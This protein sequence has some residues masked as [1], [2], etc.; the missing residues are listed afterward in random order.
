VIYDPKDRWNPPEGV[1]ARGRVSE[2]KVAISLN[3]KLGYAD[4]DGNV[5]VQPQF[6][7]AE[8]FYE[9]RA[10]VCKQGR[11]GYINPA[12]KLVIL[13]QYRGCSWFDSGVAIVKPYDQS[14]PLLIDKDGNLVREF[15][16]PWKVP[17]G[18]FSGFVGGLI[19][20]N[21]DDD[22][23]EDP[24][25]FMDPEGKWV[26]SPAYHEATNSATFENGPAIVI[27]RHYI[28]GQS[29]YAK[30]ECI[31]T[32][33]GKLGPRLLMGSSWNPFRHGLAASR[34]TGVYINEQGKVI[35]KPR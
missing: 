12:G 4:R 1:V 13:L 5:V 32:R 2:G 22:P 23:F 21:V 33:D 28:E 19:H 27:K 18:S 20:M 34:S 11:W 9:D 17:D 14:E 3:G 8:P 31:L 6:E 35:W 10:A 7:H 29:G 30:D 25:G 16:M 24:Y 15:P 26:I